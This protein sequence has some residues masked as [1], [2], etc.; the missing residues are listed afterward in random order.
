MKMQSLVTKPQVTVA[1]K[2]SDT[3]N[4]ER[5]FVTRARNEADE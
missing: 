2:H 1:V 4:G 3:T 5:H